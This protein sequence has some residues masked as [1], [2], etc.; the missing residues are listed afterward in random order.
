MKIKLQGQPVEILALLLARPGEVVTR[1][2]FQEKLWPADTFVSFE[3][4]LNA[5][6][7]RLRA[8]LGDPAEHHVCGNAGRPGLPLYRSRRSWVGAHPSGA[9]TGRRGRA[10][11]RRFLALVS[12]G[13]DGYAQCAD[14][15]GSEGTREVQE[16]L[17]RFQ[18]NAPEGS[19]FDPG[20]GLALSPDGRSLAFIASGHGKSGLWVRRLDATTARLLP[21]TEAAFGP[22]WSPDSRSIAYWASGKLWRVHVIGGAP[23]AICDQSFFIGGDWAPD[24]NIVFGAGTSGLRR[25]PASGGTPVALTTPDASLGETSHLYPNGSRAGG[26]CSWWWASRSKPGSR[27]FTEQPSGADPAGRHQRQRRVCRRAPALAAW[28]HAGRSALRSGRAPAFRRAEGHCR[29]GGRGRVRTNA[30]GSLGKP[31]CAW[32][33][34]RLAVDLAGSNAPGRPSGSNRTLGQPG[35]YS[36]FRISPDGRR[37]AVSARVR[38]WKRPMDGG[39]GAGCLEPVHVPG[40]TSRIPGLVAGRHAGDVLRGLPAEPVPQGGERSGNR[41]TGD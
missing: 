41:G 34:G 24:G 33:V 22:F 23:V 11:E 31:A 30:C 27:D 21:G 39:G 36:T 3:Q 37:V 8:G 7:R 20:R 26:C 16:H 32:A 18:L 38:R 17:H 6:M 15:L 19:Q 10:V 5:A 28:T 40:E 9:A 35:G 29:S 2:E 4:S 25:V 12:G 1:E 14:R 13:C